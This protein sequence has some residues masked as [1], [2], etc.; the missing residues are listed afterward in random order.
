MFYF[1]GKLYMIEII[2]N[3]NLKNALH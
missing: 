2:M 1:A 3:E